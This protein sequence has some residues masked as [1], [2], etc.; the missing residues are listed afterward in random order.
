MKSV[1]FTM[2]LV[3]L[4]SCCF[5][6]EQR[7]DGISERLFSDSARMVEDSIYGNSIAGRYIVKN[8]ERFREPLKEF[9]AE[10]EKPGPLISAAHLAYGILPDEEFFR[11]A[12]K[13]IAKLPVDGGELVNE[14]RD[15]LEKL[16][17]KKKGEISSREAVPMDTEPAGPPAQEANGERSP[18]LEVRE[19][20]GDS[21]GLPTWVLIAVVAAILGIMVLLIRTFLRGRAS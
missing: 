21:S 18:S 20:E 1:Q 17:Q 15:R 13:A 3:W 10:T 14:Y 11:I 6:Q 2:L 4:T 12:E 16:I 7:P 9:A 19:R 5:A 8:P